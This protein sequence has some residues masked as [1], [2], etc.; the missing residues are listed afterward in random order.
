MIE[1]YYVYVYC[2]PRV[3]SNIVVDTVNF[4]FQP[5][6]IGYGRKNRINFHL[7]MK[8][9]NFLKINKIKS[10]KSDGYLPII[11]KIKENME[12]HTAAN[13]EK[14]LIREIGTILN[15][16][17]VKNGP[18]TN[19]TPGGD[20][21]PTFFK[22]KLTEEHKDKIRKANT[23]KSFTLQRRANLSIAQKRRN[24]VIDQ[25]KKIKMLEGLKNMSDESRD[26]ISKATKNT[27]W[28]FNPILNKN[29]RIKIEN[30][31]NYLKDGWIKGFKDSRKSNHR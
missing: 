2:D 1:D 27:V 5:I 3:P 22:R 12:Q 9:S 16:L 17:G 26:N 4:E 28:I 31:D 8:D 29:R 21:G 23:G 18:L 30:I 10:I 15:V 24:I 19:Q 25:D 6:Y 13:L 11:F 7:K 20:G 14:C